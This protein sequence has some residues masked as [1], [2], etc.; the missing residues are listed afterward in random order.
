MYRLHNTR[1]LFSR[2][3]AT[4]RRADLSGSV[5]VSTIWT[6]FIGSSMKDDRYPPDSF[7]TFPF[8]SDSHPAKRRQFYGNPGRPLARTAKA[9]GCRV[10]R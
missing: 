10:E 7:E 4:A 2:T 9:Y 6:R 5:G 1:Y 3:G 8:P